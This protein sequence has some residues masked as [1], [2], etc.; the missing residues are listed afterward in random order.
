M[1]VELDTDFGCLLIIAKLI[2]I[3]HIARFKKKQAKIVG[4][5]KHKIDN[6]VHSL[7]RSLTRSSD[8]EDTTWKREI[9]EGKGKGKGKG[10]KESDNRDAAMAKATTSLNG[11]GLQGNS[12][13]STSTAE[14]PLPAEQTDSLAGT[15]GAAAQTG[16]NRTYTGVQSQV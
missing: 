7:R 6:T 16:D 3:E 11:D 12:D 1:S 13:A 5:G 9:I 15:A 4:S 10:A 8:K 2:S 14:N